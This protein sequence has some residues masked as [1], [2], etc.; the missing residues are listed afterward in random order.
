MLSSNERGT[1]N[2]TRIE[3][4]DLCT[5]LSIFPLYALENEKVRAA[6]KARDDELVKKLLKEEF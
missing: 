6:L 2:M 1:V 4:Y 5:S 3:F